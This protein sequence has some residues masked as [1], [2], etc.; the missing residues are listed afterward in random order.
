MGSK[1]ISKKS[2]SNLINIM[3]S[4]L[5]AGTCP[6]QQQQQQQPSVSS[7]LTVNNSFLNSAKKKRSSLFNLFSFTSNK[8]SSTF[9]LSKPNVNTNG[10][11]QNNEGDEGEVFVKNM[12][13]NSTSSNSSSSNTDSLA[14]RY[15]PHSIAFPSNYQTI[16]RISTCQSSKQS[17]SKDFRSITISKNTKLLQ[18]DD[19]KL[20]TSD[21]ESNDLVKQPSLVKKPSIQ[22]KGFSIPL[23]AS[24]CLNPIPINC[25]NQLSTNNSYL[26]Y[27]NSELDKNTLPKTSVSSSRAT[28][29]SS[30]C[31][32]SSV[33]AVE[34]SVNK[35]SASFKNKKIFSNANLNS[36]RNDYQQI[37]IDNPIV[38]ITNNNNNNNNNNNDDD[39]D[40]SIL[41]KPATFDLDTEG[42]CLKELNQRFKM[43]D[44]TE[45][46]IT[47]QVFI[48]RFHYF[49]SSFKFNFN[50]FT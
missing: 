16:H 6:Q 36:E 33:A 44:A 11:N 49:F 7:S 34:L 27:S 46:F 45:N 3:S 13:E 43:N 8:N 22:S 37:Y 4:S 48:F 2:S 38:N 40:D 23:N 25:I 5:M 14:L 39:L 12:E 50:M 9:S 26:K 20:L 18:L 15:R 35:K 47:E 41:F 24:Y 17:M 32:F 42:S 31:L 29:S 1:S 10:N 19:E 21:H 30:M 28:A